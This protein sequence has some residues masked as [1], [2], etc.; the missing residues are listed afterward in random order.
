MSA[1]APVFTGYNDKPY[2]IGDRVEMSPHFDLWMRGCKYGTVVGCSLTPNDRVHVL[3]DN[4]RKY[5]GKEDD[6]RGLV[7]S[8]PTND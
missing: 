3:M 7:A 6:W 8:I 4:D 2:R 5:F 1:E